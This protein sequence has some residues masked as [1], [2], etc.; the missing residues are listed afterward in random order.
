MAL[1]ESL[2]LLEIK[3]ACEYINGEIIPKPM[4]KGKHN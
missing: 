1:E 4:G 2:K 3:P